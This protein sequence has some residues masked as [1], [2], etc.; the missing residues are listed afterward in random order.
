MR[1]EDHA[2]MNREKRAVAIS[3]V[4]AAVLLTST[5]L[6]V[7]FST[8]SLGILSEAAHSGLD[9]VAAGVTVWAVRMAGVPADRNH[10]YGHGK[11]ENLSALFETVLLLGTCVWIV[12]EAVQR[13]TSEHSATVDAS[14]WAFGVVVLSIVV[15]VSR[16]RALMRVARKYDSQALEADALHFSTD[17]WSS[18]VVLLGLVGVKLAQPLGIPWLSSADA[19]AALGVAAIVFVVSLR[20]AR[21][22]VDDLL[23]AVDPKEVEAVRA[24]AHV[25]GVSAVGETRVR[26]SGPDRYVDVTVL[27]APD[28]ELAMA[29]HIADNIE[30]A[31]GAVVPRARTM[32]HLEPKEPESS[33]PTEAEA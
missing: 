33:M 3:S 9:L 14:V 18:A 1:E 31:V 7:G 21:R 16:S 4:I 5:K 20:L 13:L 6:V 17:V 25:L 22:S 26:R 32:V 29:H 12:H 10:T 27:V 28:L 24:A 11:V 19:V 2:L 30:R 23:D 8:N 15:D